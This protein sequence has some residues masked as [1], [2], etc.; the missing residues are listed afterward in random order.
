MNAEWNYYILFNKRNPRILDIK[1]WNN[2]YI[3]ENV[4]LD[5]GSLAVMLCQITMLFHWL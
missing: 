4:N 1:T 5:I 3:F 2:K